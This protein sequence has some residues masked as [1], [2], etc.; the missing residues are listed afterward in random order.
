MEAMSKY[1]AFC[2][3]VA[4]DDGLSFHDAKN[5]YRAHDRK[6]RCEKR[7]FLSLLFHKYIYISIFERFKI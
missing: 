7:T 5:N 2:L 6:E 3:P 4:I 1:A